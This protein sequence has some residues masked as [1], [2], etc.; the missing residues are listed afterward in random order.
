MLGALG[1]P[2]RVHGAFAH[3][4]PQTSSA[5]G[6][7]VLDVRY[8]L[9]HTTQTAVL[10]NPSKREQQREPTKGVDY[11]ATMIL[12]ARIALELLE[13]R[14]RRAR[15]FR[16]ELVW[17][18]CAVSDIN[19][20]S[21]VTAIRTADCVDICARYQLERARTVLIHANRPKLLERTAFRRILPN[22]GTLLEPFC[23][24]VVLLL[25]KSLSQIPAMLPLLSY[26]YYPQSVPPG[27]MTLRSDT[28]SPRH[29]LL[30]F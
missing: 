26:R 16:T 19:S 23:R 29:P 2:I 3:A 7:R 5:C 4:C 1:W 25:E 10:G 22:E 12:W 20:T 13:R 21:L 18:K 17:E 15:G 27:N 11:G 30:L 9:A 8:E 24:L 14:V 6:S 28:Y